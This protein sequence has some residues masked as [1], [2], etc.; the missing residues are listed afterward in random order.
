[1]R[2]RVDRD[3]CIGAANCVAI[4]PLV[5][6]LDQEGKSVIIKKDGS[7]S[8][9]LTEYVDLNEKDAE[10]ILEAAKSCPTLAIYVYDDDGKQIWPEIK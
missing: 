1:M 5:F 2:L 7:A 8:S 9:D 6:K 10:L 4:A 3:L